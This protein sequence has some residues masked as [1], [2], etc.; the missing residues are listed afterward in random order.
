LPEA[1]IRLLYSIPSLPGGGTERVIVTLLRYM[2]RSFFR[3]GLAV[4]DMREAAYEDDV[5]E[6]VEFIDLQCPGSVMPCRG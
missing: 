6:D 5:P 2:N 1:C 3:L 4:V